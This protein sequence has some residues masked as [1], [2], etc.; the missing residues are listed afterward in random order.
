V[1]DIVV[2]VPIRNEEER[3]GD[4]L[5]A[6]ALQEGPT[7]HAI[8]AFLN[9]CTDDTAATI[10]SLRPSLPCPVHVIEH[11]F[12]PGMDNAGNA[13]RAA[14]EHA[15]GLLGPDGLLMTTDA[16]ARVSADWIGANLAAIEAGADAVCGRAI[17][18]PLEATLI[19]DRLHADDALE[20][21]YADLLDEIHSVLDPDPADPWP[22]HTEHS[23]ASI[24][25]TKSMFE[26]AGGVPSV[27]LGEDRALLAALRRVDARIRHAPEV[28]VVVSGRTVGRAAGGMADTMRRRMIAQDPFIDD[29]L[30]PAAICATRAW[31]RGSARRAWSS[32]EERAAL[33]GQLA[34]DLRLDA[35]VLAAWMALPTFG[36]AWDLIEQRSS[37]LARQPVARLRLAAEMAHARRILKTSRSLTPV[38]AEGWLWGDV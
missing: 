10:H 6:L 38:D 18:D 32:T 11:V 4:C 27:P 3:I 23:G 30:E 14:M 20:C 36:A 37:A 8:V 29:R 33:I 1:P 16:D 12:P 19:P 35:A 17:I 7:R 15:A 25:V 22:R 34:S 28:S 21:E 9:N 5:R 24:A 2:A 13:R 26:R 31:A